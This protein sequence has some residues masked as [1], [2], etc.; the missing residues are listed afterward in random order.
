MGISD[1]GHGFPKDHAPLGLPPV[2]W[3]S[4]WTLYHRA[5]A[6][7][8][9]PALLDDPVAVELVDRCAWPL[10]A[11]FGRPRTL[12]VQYLVRRARLYDAAT[13][14]FLR[15][16]PGATVI[17]LGEGLE[18]QFWRVDNGTVRWVS[19]DLPGTVALRRA[20]LPHGPRQHTV[21]CSATDPRWTELAAAEPPV[22]IT[23][24]G[25]F[26]YLPPPRAAALIR[27]C[28]DRFPRS[29]LL[30]DTLPRWASVLG[31]SVL[32]RGGTYRFPLQE[33]ARPLA[34]L[35]LPY[36]QGRCAVAVDPIGPYALGLRVVAGPLLRAQR[37][38]LARRV[39]VPA[40]VRMDFP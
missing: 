27:L 36:A 21:A 2:S 37:C 28:A 14:D 19:V 4:L 33:G 1:T 39:P 7:R 30:F 3:T 29:V 25:L 35:L 24:Q 32:A 6:A 16:H 17:A 5:A 10:E 9:D 20:V 13:K 34:A 40:F 15:A 11:W 38:R 12:A 22:L 8:R 31:R 26:M 18:T 23:A